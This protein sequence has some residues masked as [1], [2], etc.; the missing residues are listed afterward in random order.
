MTTMQWSEAQRRPKEVVAAVEEAGEVWL[1]RRGESPLLLVSKERV[2]QTRDGL[3][4]LA[5]LLSAIGGDAGA[6]VLRHAVAIAMPWSNFLP[7]K[8]RAEFAREL[9]WT[10]SACSDLG[11]WAPLGRM[12]HEWKQTA[13]IHAEPGLAKQLSRALDA[14][15]GPVLM[16]TEGDDGGAEEG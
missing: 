12:L 14:D 1:E 2:E 7:E 4:A 5:R 8:D 6:E 16:P 3:D 11:V 9:T 13:A 15:L 10:V